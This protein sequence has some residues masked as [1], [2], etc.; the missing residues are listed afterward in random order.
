MKACIQA[1]Q[2]SAGEMQELI[3]KLR[4]ENAAYQRELDEFRSSENLDELAGLLR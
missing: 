1:E 2:L 4:Q 3:K